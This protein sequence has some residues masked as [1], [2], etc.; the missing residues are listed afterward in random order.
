MFQYFWVTEVLHMVVSLGQLVSLSYHCY[1]ARL[2]PANPRP[3]E[4]LN[5]QQKLRLCLLKKGF[6]SVP[7]PSTN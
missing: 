7:S 4:N 2:R 6:I 1:K 5:W 3:I